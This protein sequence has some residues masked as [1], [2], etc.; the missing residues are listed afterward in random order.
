MHGNRTN[1]ACENSRLVKRSIEFGVLDLN[2][3][4]FSR[5]GTLGLQ[6]Q[7]DVRI[8]HLLSLSSYVPGPALSSNPERL[9]YAHTYPDPDICSF[10]SWTTSCRL[11]REKIALDTEHLSADG[12]G[13]SINLARVLLNLSAH[14]QSLKTGRL[15]W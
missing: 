4:S 14:K 3:V 13:E 15:L 2:L 5:C 6:L 11:A 10:I 8:H 9:R 1:A 7:R 12:S